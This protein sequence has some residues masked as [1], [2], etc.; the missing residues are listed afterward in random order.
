M[1]GAEGDSVV[2]DDVVFDPT[3]CDREPI[4]IPG[5][6][7]RYGVLLVLTEPALTVAQVSDNVG[8]HFPLG[9]GSI[10]GQPLSVL[11]DPASVDQVRAALCEESW[12]EINPLHVT[13]NGVRFDGII[14]RHE[15]A[16][17]LE[18]EPDPGPIAM[19]H[20]FKTAL[21]RIQRV[22]TLPDLAAEVVDQMRRV[23][24]FERVMF[25]RF[26]EDGHGSVDAEAKDPGL[27]PYVG[28]HY[29]ASDIP[30]QARRLYLKNWLRLI[31][32]ARSTPAR[33]IPTL[34]PDTG[35]PLDLSFSVLRSVSPIHLQYMANMGTR[36]AMSI[37]L[38]VRDQLWGLISCVNHTRPWR[39]S[40]EMRAACEF[41][42]RLTSLQ[43]DA[44]DDRALLAL[45]DARGATVRA[46][47][48]AMR[49]SSGQKTV[50]AAL[51]S[52]PAEL[53]GLVAADGAALVGTGELVTCGRTPPPEIIRELAAWSDGRGPRPFSTASL[54]AQCPH[55]SEASDHASGLLTFALA[56]S[57]PWRLLWFRPEII[58]TVSWG[59]DP[60]KHVAAES[61]E[62]LRPRHSFAVWREQV[63][64]HS[65]P[66]TTSDLEA[67]DELQRCAIEIE[68]ERRLASEQ[69]AVRVRDDL[70]AIV[71]HDLKTPLSSILMQTEVI[72]RQASG[73]GTDASRL[74][75]DG[76]ARI[77]RCAD[78]MKAMVDDLLDLARIE[79]QGVDLHLQRVEIRPL[80]EEGLHAVAPLAEI[81]R[82]SLAAQLI[83]SPTLEADPKRIFRVLSNLVGNAIKFS[84][85]GATVTVRMGCSGGELSIT[86]V[87][88]G[89]G[90]AADALP[91]V[92]DRYWKAKSS[93]QVGAGL[94]LYIAKGIVDAHGGRIWAECSAGSTSFI[95]TLPL[96]R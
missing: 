65:R 66:W 47:D 24:G 20:P 58:K 63:K 64:Q 10:L 4:H 90:I 82:I 25:Y 85:V 55:A 12:Y 60:T 79:A 31:F 80:I 42:G 19:R 70:I 48:V 59:G 16:A 1:A 81:K 7:Q 32:D 18:L 40:H 67:A 95:F 3:N 28:L 50:L 91:H 26:H 35:E 87:D 71:S 53:M 78:H 11:L 29:P 6:V 9:V 33:L 41:L 69:R 74:L 17:I 13:A 77:R 92:F 57:T 83:D 39:V 54:V 73:N 96:T 62:P 51:F 44:L 93:D 43:I 38:I 68:L 36:S 52:H 8:D 88:N 15:G 22:T 2:T 27:E 30:A 5:T 49:Q 21:T 46:L 76:A 75:R 94:G 45:R 72:S 37:S 86:V 56:V 14:H 61:G 34:R 23:T 84:P 89:P